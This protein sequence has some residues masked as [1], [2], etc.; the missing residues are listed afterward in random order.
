MAK[1]KFQQLQDAVNAAQTDA[2]AFYGSKNKAA[3][4]R[5]RGAL[6]EIRG[7]AKEGRDEVTDI[8]SKM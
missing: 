5:L 8:K 7:L 1:N 3:G 6:Q 2:A 4:T